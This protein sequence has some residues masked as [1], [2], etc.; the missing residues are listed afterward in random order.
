M[1]VRND[2]Q[3]SLLGRLGVNAPAQR[4]AVLGA[5]ILF[6]L[7]TFI[8]LGSHKASTPAVSGQNNSIA[9]SG[10][11]DPPGGVAGGKNGGDAKPVPSEVA[12][13]AYEVIDKLKRMDGVMHGEVLVPS[14]SQAMPAADRQ[15]VAKS[16]A[17]QEGFDVVLLFSTRDAQKAAY[18]ESFSNAHPDASAGYLGE[19]GDGKFT[20]AVAAEQKI[21]VELDANDLARLKALAMKIEAF[22]ARFHKAYLA[23]KQ[24]ENDPD[25]KKRIS[26][27]E[28]YRQVFLTDNST[29]YEEVEKIQPP[30][31][32]SFLKS[33]LQPH[34]FMYLATSQ[35]KNHAEYQ[36]RI[37][38]YEANLIKVNDFLKR[39][40][41]G[42]AKVQSSN[43]ADN[44]RP[45][46]WL[47]ETYKVTVRR[48]KDKVWEEVEETTG[49]VVWRYTETARTKDYTELYCPKRKYEIR[50][51]TKRME[52]KKDGKWTWVAD[53]RWAA[54][55]GGPDNSKA[56]G[57]PKKN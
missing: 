13:P 8:P 9:A 24:Y 40:K 25:V 55:S 42:V 11:A 7:L 2:W 29:L 20:P 27:W 44:D 48:V 57:I 23:K 22:H 33:I 31:A 54:P 17:E 39:S 47:N 34:A 37:A 53:G 15:R 52:L 32:K 45:S 12:L 30:R 10:T 41:P 38:E 35:D 4:H 3:D 36:T 26:A 1:L 18:S 46:R 56:G 19:W 43:A 5:T 49:R 16:I 51:L 6:M 50:L 28:S 14:Y 21:E